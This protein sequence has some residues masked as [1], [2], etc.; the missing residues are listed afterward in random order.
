MYIYMYICIYIYVYMYI[1]VI[2]VIVKTMC[3]SWSSLQW[4]SD[5]SCTWGYDV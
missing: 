2:Y 5:N 1:Y 4:L 3:P